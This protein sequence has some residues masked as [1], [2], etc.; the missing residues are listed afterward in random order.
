MAIPA[1]ACAGSLP[2]LPPESFEVNEHSTSSEPV[3]EVSSSSSGRLVR[4]MLR[5]AQESPGADMAAIVR[6]FWAS[7]HRSR[8]RPIATSR[9]PTADAVEPEAPLHPGAPP[10][11][12]PQSPPITGGPLHHGDSSGSVSWSAASLS[13]VQ[14]QQPDVFS[15]SARPAVSAGSQGPAAMES[16]RAVNAIG[17]SLIPL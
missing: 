14:L 16:G 15:S 8:N 10:G 4:E 6:A 11:S 3:S 9:T 13:G 17:R 7:P 2:R 5:A 12:H 1:V